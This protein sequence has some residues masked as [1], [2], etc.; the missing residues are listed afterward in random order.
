MTNPVGKSDTTVAVAMR[1]VGGAGLCV[2]VGRATVTTS[3]AVKS[4][5]AGPRYENRL[6]ANPLRIRQG[7]GYGLAQ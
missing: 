5:T 6:H 7:R 2:F 4:K 1:G 3:T